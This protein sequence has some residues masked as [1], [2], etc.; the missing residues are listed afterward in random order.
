[1]S[2][3]ER[4]RMPLAWSAL[5]PWVR[6]AEREIWL[7]PMP[8]RALFDHQWIYVLKGWVRAEFDGRKVTLL[9]GDLWIIEPGVAHA[10]VPEPTQ[11]EIFGVHFDYQTQP[12]SPRWQYPLHE[13]RRVPPL[14]RP[15]CLPENL[16]LSGVYKAAAL[17][18]L[19]APFTELVSAFHERRD[20]DVLRVR[21]RWFDL[22]YL[23]V[24]ALAGTGR[25]GGSLIRHRTGVARAVSWLEA[26]YAQPL[27]REALARRVG[28]SPTHLTHLFKRLTG[29]SPLRHQQHL[30]MSEAKRLLRETELKHREIARRV[31]YADPYHFSRAFKQYEGMAPRSYAELVRRA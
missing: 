4:A 14:R 7:S 8:E 5:Q 18:D 12:D 27:D 2:G 15:I 10:G 9:P 1:M 23:L 26:H 19:R 6:Y 3:R 21:A 24:R 29:R 11:T 16:V 13:G 17:P 25:P 31:G 20:A 30:R 22:L 28:L